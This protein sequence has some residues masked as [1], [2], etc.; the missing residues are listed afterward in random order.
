MGKEH[1]KGGQKG[2]KKACI[3]VFVGLYRTHRKYS[4]DMLSRWT[5]KLV[6]GKIVN[7]GDDGDNDKANLQI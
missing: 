5:Q 4:R 3:P 7:D 1:V 2:L 6:R